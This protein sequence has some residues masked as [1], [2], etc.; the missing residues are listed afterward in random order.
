M[1]LFDVPSAAYFLS[2]EKT[3]SVGRKV[4]KKC[5][6]SGAGEADFPQIP[7]VGTR[8]NLACK[9]GCFYKVNRWTE[10]ARKI[11]MVYSGRLVCVLF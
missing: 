4:S 7:S 9:R 5:R 8:D 3:R 2:V 10:L 6:P 1:F 11:L